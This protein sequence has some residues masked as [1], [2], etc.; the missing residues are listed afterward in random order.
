MAL[1][2]HGSAKPM[3]EIWRAKFFSLVDNDG[4]SSISHD[5]LLKDF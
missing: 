2:T 5:W 1:E 4:V 3:A